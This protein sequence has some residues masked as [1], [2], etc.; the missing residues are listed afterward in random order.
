M[1]F[2]MPHYPNELEIRDGWLSEAGMID[3][4]PVGVAYRS[5]NPAARL[6]PIALNQSRG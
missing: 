4:K 3:F 2:P 5:S 6:V 1:R